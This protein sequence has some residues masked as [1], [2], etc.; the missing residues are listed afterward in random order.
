[1]MNGIW[2]AAA[3][4][5]K[6][7]TYAAALAAA[8]GIFFLAYS[9]ALLT[10]VCAGRI[11]R[12]TRTLVYVAVLAGVAVVMASSASMSGDAGGLADAGLIRMILQAGEGR[13]TLIRFIGLLLIAGGL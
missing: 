8:G 1:M 7:A 10:D 5:A 3:V 9:E 12:L 13:A 2:E 11:R 4:A 6:A